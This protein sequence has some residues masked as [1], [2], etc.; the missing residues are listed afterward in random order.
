MFTPKY[1]HDLSIIF[2]PSGE[3]DCKNS[4]SKTKWNI[5]KNIIYL[6]LY[7]QGIFWRKYVNDI[8]C[9]WPRG[10]NIDEFMLINN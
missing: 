6:M 2:Q 5:T 4:K 8:F 7:T 9:L 3:N 10:I 1:F